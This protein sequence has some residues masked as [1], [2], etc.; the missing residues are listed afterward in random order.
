MDN[1]LIYSKISLEFH[2]NISL[3]KD[4]FNLKTISL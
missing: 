3:I 2:P 4:S 1:Y